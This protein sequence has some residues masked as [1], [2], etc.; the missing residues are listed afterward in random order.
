MQK[1]SLL[2]DFESGQPHAAEVE[3]DGGIRVPDHAL[4]EA[5]RPG[6]PVLGVGRD[7][8]ADELVPRDDLA[9][10]YLERVA[11]EPAGRRVSQCC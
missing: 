11:R 9:P 2:L 8:E 10:L 4:L 5:A 1:V 7:D 3:A 6:S